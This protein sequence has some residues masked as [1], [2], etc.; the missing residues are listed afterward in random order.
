MADLNAFAVSPYPS[1][2]FVKPK[3]AKKKPVTKKVTAG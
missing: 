1:L 2:F 3:V